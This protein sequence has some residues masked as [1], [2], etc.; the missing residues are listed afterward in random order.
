MKVDKLRETGKPMPVW[1]SVL[2]ATQ[3]WA[4]DGNRGHTVPWVC[5][6]GRAVYTNAGATAEFIEPLG[7]SLERGQTLAVSWRPGETTYT[8]EVY[9]QNHMCA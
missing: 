6:L 9:R 8:M 1:L 3:C 7:I 4:T 2:F 5:V